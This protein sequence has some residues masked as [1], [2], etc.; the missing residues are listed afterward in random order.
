MR[1]LRRLHLLRFRG[2]RALLSLEL[3]ALLSS[4]EVGLQIVRIVVGPLNDFL[5]YDQLVAFTVDGALPRSTLPLQNSFIPRGQVQLTVALPSFPSI[6]H[7][8]LDVGGA[9]LSGEATDPRV[10]V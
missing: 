5:G 2:K 9:F 10:L 8:V 6:P 4:G 3:F 1:A 7:N